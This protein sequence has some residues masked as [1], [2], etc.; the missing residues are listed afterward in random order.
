M[1]NECGNN[2]RLRVVGQWGRGG[3]GVGVASNGLLDA[4]AVA[5]RMWRYSLVRQWRKIKSAAVCLR[6]GRRETGE[7]DESV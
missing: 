7:L 5:T 4:R 6:N 2:A 3:A 1:G